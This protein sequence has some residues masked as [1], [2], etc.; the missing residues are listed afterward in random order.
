MP[1]PSSSPDPARV[2]FV[3]G[4]HRS[5]TSALAGVL[6]ELGVDFGASLLE[7]KAD[8]PKGFFE[9]RRIVEL[10]D[11]VFALFG[12]S[13]D[14][15]RPMPPEWWRDDRLAPLMDEAVAILANEFSPGARRA[16]KDPRISRLLPF[17]LAVCRRVGLAPVFIQIIRHPDEVAASLARRNGYSRLKSGLLWLL[18]VLDSGAV[19]EAYPRRLL[20]YDS[21]MADWRG[22][23]ASLAD[24][25]GLD[26]PMPEVAAHAIDGFLD[27]ALRHHRA[28]ADAPPAGTADDTVIAALCAEAHALLMAADGR[29]LTAEPPGLAG[30]RAR[31]AGHLAGA[32]PW[33]AEIADLNGLAGR[34]TRNNREAWAVAEA[35]DRMLVETHAGHTDGVALMAAQRD[36]LV[37]LRAAFAELI[38]VSDQSDVR[39]RAADLELAGL[40]A[41][42]GRLLADLDACRGRLDEARQRDE[43]A[44]ADLAALAGR[45]ADKDRLLAGYIAERATL[46]ATVMRVLSGWRQR[47]LPPESRR[48][49]LFTLLVRFLAGIYY[50]GWRET[51]RQSWA[52]LLTRAKARAGVVPVAVAPA[53]RGTTMPEYTRWIAAHEPSPEALAAQRQAAAVVTAPVLFSVVLPVYKVPTAVL[54]ATLDSL[55]AQT[56]PHWEACVA[57]ADLDNQD[58]WRLLREMAAGDPRIRLL[59]LEA[60]AGI[61]GNSDA[62]L[63]LASGEFIALLDHDDELTPWALYEMAERIAGDPEID[64]LYSDKDC[65]DEAGSL[66]LNPLFKPEWS[67]EMLFSVNYLTHLC[68]LRRSLVEAVGGWRPETDG[69]QDWDIFYRVTERARKIAR[70]VGVHYHWRIISTSVATGLAAKPYAALG[71]L[72]TQ[73]ERVRRLGLAASVVPD[74]EC[75]FRLLW[76]LD[77]TPCVDVVVDGDVDDE[78]LERTLA[79][80]AKQLG[81]LS[82][83]VTVVRPAGARVVPAEAGATRVEFAAPAGKTAAL[84]A[85]AARGR[86]PVILFVDAGLA[87]LGDLCAR[88]L[89]GWTRLHPEIAFAGAVLLTGSDVVVEAGRVCGGGLS[90]PLFR[91]TPLRHWGWFGGPLWFRNVSAVAPAAAAFKRTDWRPADPSAQTLAWPDAFV[92]QCLHAQAGGRRGLVDPHAR[93]WLDAMPDAVPAWHPEFARDSY[94]HP[95]F[96]SVSPLMLDEGGS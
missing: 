93:V 17:W 16:I 92:I 61:S 63:A 20:S 38:R 22:V 96:G 39:S 19:A 30:L 28:G 25:A 59:R 73:E 7:A 89:T 78:R 44:Q 79:A 85:A 62:A 23:A 74:D 64:F 91:D 42:Q 4:M 83:S 32:A 27:P 1:I 57:Y 60:N 46:C 40:R 2:V 48:G 56:W 76:R 26:G 95:A 5:G 66:R 10:D 45:L 94:F 72:R 36:E 18:H 49:E 15:L 6:G 31:L 24:F 55:Q 67:P 34:L 87:R 75:G 80:L 71:Q 53:A 11:R 47:Y 86:A 29:E 43:A 21:L 3:L 90:A 14:D 88:E 82:S 70:V 54:R 37:E 13:H 8:N 52:Y 58:N 77:E 68:V 84:F 51:L 33:L 12:R 50:R 41:A 65:I 35:K 81:G 9:N 69:A